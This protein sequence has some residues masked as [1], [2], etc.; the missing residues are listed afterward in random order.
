MACA[1]WPSD[2]RSCETQ[3]QRGGQSTRQLFE[4]VFREMALKQ[5]YSAAVSVL[6]LVLTIMKAHLVS[7]VQRLNVFK[8]QT[9][10]QMFTLPQAPPVQLSTVH[11]MYQMRWR[12]ACVLL[13]SSPIESSLL[14]SSLQVALSQYPIIAGRFNAKQKRIDM[15]PPFGAAFTV[16]KRKDLCASCVPP[17]L[18]F[19]VP[20][21][22]LK[23]FVD[24]RDAE[25]IASGKEPMAAVRVTYLGDGTMA[26]GLS[27]FHVVADGFSFYQFFNDWARS[28]RELAGKV[29]QGDCLF[30][31]YPEQVPFC[32]TAFPGYQS[33]HACVKVPHLFVVQPNLFISQ[34]ERDFGRLTTAC[35][36]SCLCLI[37]SCVFFFLSYCFSLFPTQ[38]SYL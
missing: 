17:Y 7:I 14:Q 37:S 22:M 26:I 2:H 30:A 13:F 11:D 20:C 27:M 15:N 21:D 12:I 25:Q 32:R 38:S 3:P 10:S 19:L 23:T 29:D 33:L 31:P 16:C 9:S 36:L 28:C 8:Q 1:Q 24:H 18:S 6:R 34:R 5:A 35:C 4:A